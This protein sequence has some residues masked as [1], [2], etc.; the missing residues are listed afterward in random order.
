L[1]AKLTRAPYRYFFVSKSGV[2]KTY[3]REEDFFRNVWECTRLDKSI[4]MSILGLHGR[5]E[6]PSGTFRREEL[7]GGK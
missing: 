2:E 3:S 4:A 1:P 7:G 6:H 5:I